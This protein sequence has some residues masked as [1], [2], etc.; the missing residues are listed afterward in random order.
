MPNDEGKITFIDLYN[1]ITGQA[2][3]MFDGEVEDKEEFETTVTTSI[4][5]ALSAL[6]CSYKFVFRNKK[7]KITTRA[8]ISEYNRPNGNIIRKTVGGKNVYGIKIDKNFLNYAPDYEILEE[9]SGKPEAFFI[10]NDKICLYPTPDKAYT[11]NVE[12]L[13]FNAACDSEGTEK[14]NLKEETDYINIDERYADLFENTLMPLAMTYLIASDTDENFSQY[15]AQ[16][17]NAYKNLIEM[18]KGA[19]IEKTIG[20]R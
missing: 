17:E 13:T 4:Q 2:W 14:A 16:Y 12:Y 7:S 10:Q 1:K 11:V 8:G 5:K 3:S 18:C 20:W 19:D 6:W 9:K 15:K